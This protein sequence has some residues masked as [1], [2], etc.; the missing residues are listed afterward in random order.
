MSER[1]FI[2]KESKQKNLND[3]LDGLLR[4]IKIENEGS[5]KTTIKNELFNLWNKE[6]YFDE[7]KFVSDVKRIL[8]NIGAEDLKNNILNQIITKDKDG[9]ERLNNRWRKTLEDYYRT[10]PEKKGISFRSQIKDANEVR[11]WLYLTLQDDQVRNK[12]K[13]D[14]ER[15]L[16]QREPIFF[17]FWPPSIINGLKQLIFKKGKPIGFEENEF[18]K[19]VLSYVDD[20]QKGRSRRTFWFEKD[21]LPKE[22][23]RRSPGGLKKLGIEIKDNIY[24]FYLTRDRIRDLLHNLAGVSH[25]IIKQETELKKLFR[26]TS[27]I[28]REILEKAPKELKDE[29][30]PYGNLML[31]L[32]K[33]YQDLL[34]S[35]G[36][37]KDFDTIKNDINNIKN[38][39]EKRKK[40]IEA[41]KKP[42]EIKSKIKNF[43]KENGLL[44]LSS[45][46]LWGLAMGWFLP[47]WLIDYFYKNTSSLQK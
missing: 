9:N 31:S 16:S 23:K 13:S 22:L 6:E 45:V 34:E 4:G 46:G 14:F 8:A 44:I 18:F 11:A 25:E 40:D 29:I 19:E 41:G 17:K 3:H 2:R 36:N 30:L 1:F 20:L 33:S 12:L 21:L 42:S 15:A 39:L 37:E 47:L 38:D 27:E 35:G 24:E 32:A 5:L 7:E 10:S 43:I 28:Y 26:E